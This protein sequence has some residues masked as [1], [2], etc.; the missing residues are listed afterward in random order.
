MNF[1]PNHNPYPSA[2][3][4]HYAKNGM[5]ATSHPLAAQAGLDMI[6]RG[7]NAVDAAIAAA[8]CL[9]VT[10][11]TSNGI[12][13]DAFAI[14]WANGKMAGLNSSG[15]AP[16]AISIDAVKS[17]G[18]SQMPKTGWLPVTVP[19]VPGA[20]AAL[21]RRF[22][23]LTLAQCLK[24]AIDY[25]REGFAVSPT[26][27]KYWGI[28]MKS[29]SKLTGDEFA[30]FFKTF[31]PDGRVPGAGD[32]IRLP[33]HANTLEE[34][35][36]T[37]AESFY[38]GD[39]ADKIAAFSQKTG[40]FLAKSDLAAFQPEFVTPISTSYRGYDIWEMPP[41][42][43]GLVALIALNILKG[44]EFA[45]RDCALTFH[46]QF[47]AIKLAFAAG[48]EFIT[49]PGH[50][51]TPASALLSDDYASQLRGQIGDTAAAPAPIA[52]KGGGTV[53]LAAAD[54]HGN[55]V[56][57]IQS[58][59]MGFGSGIAVPGTGIALQNRGADFSL[60]GAHANALAGG[61]RSY[62]TIIP[63]FITRDKQAIGPFGVMGGYMQ[64][65]GHVQ[66]VQNCIDFGLGPQAAL[67]AP[68]WQW[69][70]G[71]AFHVEHAFPRHIAQ[72]LSARGH[73]MHVAL[74]SG[75][76]GRGQIIW[77]NPETGV[78]AGGTEARCDGAIAAW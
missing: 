72:Q 23:A 57:Y 52:P 45:S 11:P 12:G 56:S 1:D 20:W 15:P 9:T 2:R 76:F 27:A 46:R 36:E 70:Q 17:L 10:E 62:H 67:D 34:I 19:G 8:A 65:Q 31:A 49:D 75:S 61:K 14:V 73:E 30:P 68:R 28:A 50:M 53:Y 3:A 38:R 18:H 48:K 40:G 51:Q 29:Y 5:V 42:G 44:Y 13:G 59:Y 39:L 24:P 64:P 25:A 60:D 77:R 16:M 66:M 63:G 33:H 7:G 26:V 6:K 55:M 37:M 43:Q 32:I 21:S 4:V 78:L 69:T 54:G 47:E 35:G 58:N 41:N 71:R 74:D 22:G